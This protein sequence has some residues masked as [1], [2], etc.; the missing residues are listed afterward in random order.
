MISWIKQDPDAME[1][2]R[3]RRSIVTYQIELLNKLELARAFSSWRVV[4][5]IVHRFSTGQVD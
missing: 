4:R 1:Y 3:V 2:Y 5:L